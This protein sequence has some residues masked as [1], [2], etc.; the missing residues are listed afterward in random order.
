MKPTLQKLE[1]WGYHT[2]K[3]AYP[4]FNRFL[5][6]HTCDGQTDGRTDGN[7]EL[8]TIRASRG[9]K[10]KNHAFAVKFVVKNLKPNL[11]S[12]WH[13][14]SS[15]IFNRMMLVINFIRIK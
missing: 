13:Y 7:T 14:K 9:N 6:I 10:I 5:L 2:V 12:A 4:N 8:R 11:I 1:G 3:I 15:I